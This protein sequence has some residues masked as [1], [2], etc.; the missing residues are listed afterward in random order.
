M[1][2]DIRKIVILEEQQPCCRAIIHTMYTSLLALLVQFAERDTYAEI[3]TL[4][5]IGNAELHAIHRVYGGRRYKY[6][7]V[8]AGGHLDPLAFYEYRR[9]GRLKR[10]D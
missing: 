7:R 5:K 2:R 9:Y 8:D 3:C 6:S 1:K 10:A 4:R